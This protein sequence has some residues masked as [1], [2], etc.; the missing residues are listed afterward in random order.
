M[1]IRSF[2]LGTRDHWLVMDNLNLHCILG[3]RD[4]E[5]I[6]C[7]RSLCVCLSLFHLS[8]CCAT[9][10]SIP[11]LCLC[12]FEHS[13]PPLSLFHLSV[14]LFYALLHKFICLSIPRSC[15]LG[16]ALEEASPEHQLKG[17]FTLCNW[18]LQEGS[19][20]LGSRTPGHVHQNLLEHFWAML[21]WLS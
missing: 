18:W 13:H 10:V 4:I 1:W 16:L 3:S 14:L 8:C 5:T 21:A 6:M 20:H 19:M 17:F 9:Y 15:I 2:P 12:W 7:P 11:H